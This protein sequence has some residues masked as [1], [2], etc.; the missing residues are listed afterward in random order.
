MFFFYEKAVVFNRFLQYPL[1]QRFVG[2]NPSPHLCVYRNS[3]TRLHLKFTTSFLVKE[4]IVQTTSQNCKVIQ[5]CMKFPIHIGPSSGTY[6]EMMMTL[7]SYLPNLCLSTTT[8]TSLPRL[9]RYYTCH[10]A[11]NST[12]QEN[13]W[14]YC[15]N[16][17]AFIRDICPWKACNSK[18]K[19]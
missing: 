18:E 13:V 2:S 4:N 17:L 7:L 15:D 10:L 1:K 12:Y 9:G 16:Y 11:Q 5:W 8:I 6:I 14:D 19:Q 3:F